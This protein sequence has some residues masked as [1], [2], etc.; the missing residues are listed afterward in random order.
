MLVSSFGPSTC[1]LQAGGLFSLD[2][3]LSGGVA[4]AIDTGASEGTS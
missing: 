1:L 2:A 3:A 4:A